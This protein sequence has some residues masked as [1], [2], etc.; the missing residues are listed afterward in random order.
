MTDRNISCAS[1]QDGAAGGQDALDEAGTPEEQVEAHPGVRM[2]DALSAVLTREIAAIEAREFEAL[3]ALFEEKS[4]LVEK[5]EQEPP[6]PGEALRAPLEDLGA[7]ARRDSALLERMID[8][9]RSVQQ[10]VTRIRDR[11]HT[12]G[13]YGSEGKKREVSVARKPRLDTSY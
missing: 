4:A 10:E 7:L 5:L 11:H 1:A 3:E 13:V 12:A 6:I 9:T 8:A 2:I